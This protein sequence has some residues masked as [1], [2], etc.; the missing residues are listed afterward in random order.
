MKTEKQLENEIE[1]LKEELASKRPPWYE[2]YIK[3][4]S[5]INGFM[6]CMVISS[7]VA[8]AQVVTKP[9]TFSS[10]TVIS[11]AEVNAN[12][13]TLYTRINQIN[14]GFIA[15]L[16]SNFAIIC[17]NPSMQAGT[18]ETVPFD[19]DSS[20]N[21]GAVYNNATGVFTAPKS[22]YYWFI[23]D[24]SF[25]GMKTSFYYQINGAFSYTNYMVHYMNYGKETR[26][27][28][29]NMGDTLTFAADCDSS[30]GPANDSVLVGSYYGLLL[31]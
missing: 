1:K 19:D 15:E 9:H 13:D 11:A 2:R 17:D 14:P 12:F 6:F 7:V 10:G 25:S 28:K 3:R 26:I 27:I 5:F 24:I 16:S 4:S 22:G 18:I 8:I 21:D 30:M 31:M 20:K 29:L 23:W